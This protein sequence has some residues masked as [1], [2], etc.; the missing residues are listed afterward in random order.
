MLRERMNSVGSLEPQR[1]DVKEAVGWIMVVLRGAVWIG[2]KD[3]SS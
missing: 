3:D 2:M 1:R